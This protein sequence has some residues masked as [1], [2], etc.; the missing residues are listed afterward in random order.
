MATETA[1]RSKS[2]VSPKSIGLTARVQ[3]TDQGAR[4]YFDA[5]GRVVV[6]RQGPWE[7]KRLWYDAYPTDLR[8][9][10]AENGLVIIRDPVTDMEWFAKVGYLE[11]QFSR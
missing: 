4:A 10:L 5:D 7:G 11:S 9:V 8:V 3:Q 2:I 1:P 6:V